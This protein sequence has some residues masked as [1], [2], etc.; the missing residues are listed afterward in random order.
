MNSAGTL[1]DSRIT[2]PKLLSALNKSNDTVT[3]GGWGSRI[4]VGPDNSNF[5]TTVLI[6][7]QAQKSASINSRTCGRHK[8][9]IHQRHQVT[10]TVSSRSQVTEDTHHLCTV[11][12]SQT[13]RECPNPPNLSL[14]NIAVYTTT[15]TIAR[16]FRR[17]ID[18]CHMLAIKIHSFTTIIFSL[19][20]F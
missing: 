7:L 18:T 1:S 13:L 6:A 9:S 3:M 11:Y 17:Y 2:T 19:S 15:I 16:H 12:G 14:V 20:I 8:T 10:Q 4:K 5:R